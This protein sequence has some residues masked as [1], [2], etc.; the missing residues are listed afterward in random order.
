MKIKKKRTHCFLFL[1]KRQRYRAKGTAV[2]SRSPSP[3][4][5]SEFL[6][7]MQQEIVDHLD[8]YSRQALAYTGKT[9]F[10]KWGKYDMMTDNERHRYRLGIEGPETYIKWQWLFYALEPNTV[11]LQKLADIMAGLAKREDIN[12][13]RAYF[14]EY[15]RITAERHASGYGATLFCSALFMANSPKTLLMVVE[16][17]YWYLELNYNSICLANVSMLYS[18][19]DLFPSHVEMMATI[20]CGWKTIE[21]FSLYYGGVNHDRGNLIWCHK[22]LECAIAKNR[23]EFLYASAAFDSGMWWY[24]NT[25]DHI[26]SAL[27][28]VIESASARKTNYILE[29]KSVLY[30]LEKRQLALPA[31]LIETSLAPSLQNMAWLLLDPTSANDVL[32]HET[33]LPLFETMVSL[34]PRLADILVDNSEVPWF[35]LTT[36]PT[37]VKPL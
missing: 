20:R 14:T 33:L 12:L 2:V 13:F 19:N 11:P 37:M 16:R 7:E 4:V 36:T 5:W 24:M 8:Y 27:F 9:C 30:L 35:S 25:P 6:P 21:G 18:D 1:M 34:E 22:V 15:Q 17:D 3:W 31:D 23:L 29:A 10:A 28:S 32:I 26:Y